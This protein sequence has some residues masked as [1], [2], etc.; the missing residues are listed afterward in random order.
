MTSIGRNHDWPWTEETY[1][2]CEGCGYAISPYETAD[3]WL[4]RHRVTRR[5]ACSDEHGE[6][7]P[8]L[9]HVNGTTRVP[10]YED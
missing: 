3:G 10:G 1:A 4:W 8:K 2:I 9:A 5:F 7:L 6:I